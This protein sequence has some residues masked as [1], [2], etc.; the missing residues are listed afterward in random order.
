M[1]IKCHLALDYNHAYI[2]LYLAGSNDIGHIVLDVSTYGQLIE[3]SMLISVTT[4]SGL[5]SQSLEVSIS[6]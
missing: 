6:K 2:R 4:D 3:T 1:A 5:K